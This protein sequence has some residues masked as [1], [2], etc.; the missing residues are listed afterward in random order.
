MTRSFLPAA[1]TSLVPVV[2]LLGALTCLLMMAY[3][4]SDTWWRLLI[5][6]GIGLVIYFTYG[7]RNSRLN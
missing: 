5:W 7:R 3:L 2:P 6:M 4:P 1:M